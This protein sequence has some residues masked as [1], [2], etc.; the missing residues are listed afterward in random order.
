M[1]KLVVKIPFKRAL[2]SKTV[3]KKADSDDKKLSERKR[4]RD[5]RLKLKHDPSLRERADSL[6]VKKRVQNSTYAEQVKHR[7]KYSWIHGWCATL[8]QLR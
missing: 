7:R 8:C 4:I 1:A 6:K 3:E 5:Y 2:W